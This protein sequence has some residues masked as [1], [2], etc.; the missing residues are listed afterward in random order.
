MRISVPVADCEVHSD[1]I[2]AD[3]SSLPVA[4]PDP[5]QIEDLFLRYDVG[6]EG[7]SKPAFETPVITKVVPVADQGTQVL[8]SDQVKLPADEFS[9]LWHKYG[10]VSFERTKLLLELRQLGIDYELT[11]LDWF[12]QHPQDVQ[13]KLDQI[14]E[15]SSLLSKCSVGLS[16]FGVKRSDTLI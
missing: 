11:R 13:Q 3:R 1:L 16:K 12:T 6:E 14:E 7:N 10:S 2:D 9:D 5:I 8:V 4:L 15:L